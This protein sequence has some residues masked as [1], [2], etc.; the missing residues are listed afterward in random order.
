MQIN[1][2]KESHKYPILSVY[3]TLMAVPKLKTKELLDTFNNCNRKIQF[4][5]R[6]RF[7]HPVFGLV[8]YKI[9]YRR[10]KNKLVYKTYE[11]EQK[12]EL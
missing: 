11:F 8:D 1:P 4:T 2:N 12:T 5:M 10:A 9:R 3:D 7:E 6:D